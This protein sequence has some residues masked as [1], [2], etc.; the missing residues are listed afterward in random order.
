MNEVGAATVREAERVDDDLC[1]GE[2]P[3]SRR[4]CI[5]N[6][7]GVVRDGDDHRVSPAFELVRD[8]IDM[9]GAVT[10]EVAMTDEN[11]VRPTSALAD[12]QRVNERP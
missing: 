4:A 3:E 6:A 11:D 9:Q 10:G 2:H 5:R 7:L 1:M 8:R 12:G